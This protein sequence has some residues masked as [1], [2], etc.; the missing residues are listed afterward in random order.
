[1]FHFRY[2]NY[3]HALGHLFSTGQ[4]VV[5]NRSPYS[6]IVFLDAMYRNGLITKNARQAIVDIQDNTLIELKRPH[7]VIY[8]DV[9]AAVTQVSKPLK[10]KK[11]K[12]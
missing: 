6:D 7:L 3:I 9:P 2:A 12:Q 11:K 8:L 1:M 4:G 10:I 5:M